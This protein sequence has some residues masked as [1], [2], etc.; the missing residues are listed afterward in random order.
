[1]YLVEQ[2]WVQFFAKQH[3]NVWKSFADL[4]ELLRN[5]VKMYFYVLLV[6]TK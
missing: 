1:M 6:Q 5:G 3:N 4:S 2:I